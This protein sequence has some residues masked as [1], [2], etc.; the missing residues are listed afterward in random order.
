VPTK[1]TT[2][3]PATPTRTRKA[4]ATKAAAPAPKPTKATAKAT[5]TKPPTKAPAK[6][7]SNLVPA[8]KRMDDA[9]LIAAITK[10]I[11]ADESLAT[12]WTR[13]HRVMRAAGTVSAG[14]VRFREA[15]EAALAAR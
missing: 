11:A 1:K 14:H 3:E 4:T 9:Q 12:S 2:S 8:T 7:T 13:A 6:R 15:Y 10:A 5:T